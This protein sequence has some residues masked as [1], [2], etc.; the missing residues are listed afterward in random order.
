[1]TI[2][3]ITSYYVFS[4]LWVV[5]FVVKHA[6]HVTVFWHSSRIVLWYAHVLLDYLHR[7]AFSGRYNTLK[8]RPRRRSQLFKGLIDNAIST[9]RY[10]IT[11]ESLFLI[12]IYIFYFN[13]YPLHLV[14]YLIIINFIYPRIYRVHVALLLISLS[15][16]MLEIY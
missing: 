10:S 11:K 7:R 16:Q 15:N 9:A 2:I 8:Y 5:D 13:N 3:L 4:S 12:C 14:I 6:V 1:M